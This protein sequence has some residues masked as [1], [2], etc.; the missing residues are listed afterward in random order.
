MAHGTQNELQQ[1]ALGFEPHRQIGK[2]RILALQIMNDHVNKSRQRGGFFQIDQRESRKFQHAI[3]ARKGLT[4][5][6]LVERVAVHH[7]VEEIAGTFPF[8]PRLARRRDDQSRAG[9]HID[10]I[11]PLAGLKPAPQGDVQGHMVVVVAPGHRLAGALAIPGE[12]FEAHPANPGLGAPKPIETRGIFDF[13][14]AAALRH[15]E[16]CAARRPDIGSHGR[17]GPG[18]EGRA[19][20]D[21]PRHRGWNRLDQPA[22][23]ALRTF[24]L[25]DRS[26]G[27]TY[28]QGCDFLR[29]QSN[30]CVLRKV[31][32]FCA[33][34]GH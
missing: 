6:A 2:G 8:A 11:P 16:D 13:E 23:S 21:P 24:F 12:E 34:T 1:N 32:S 28:P 22:H 17:A 30:P 31:R 14:G 15:F 20:I 29:P 5:D 25:P 19:E 33:R 10:P 27:L 3:G 18:R 4:R 7:N 9:G 26:S